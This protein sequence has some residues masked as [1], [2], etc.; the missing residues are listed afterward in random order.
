MLGKWAI[1]D[2]ETTGLDASYEHI[3]D[4]GYLQFDGLKLIRSYSSLV[5]TDRQLSQFLQ[6]LTGITPEMVAKAP[7]WKVVKQDL[8]EL[9]GHTLIAHN[10]QFEGQFLLPTFEELKVSSQASEIDGLFTDTIPFFALL[11]PGRSSLNLESFILEHQI[12]DKEMHRGLE[13]S[14]DLLKVMIAEC[15]KLLDS[16]YQ[17]RIREIIKNKLPS[18]WFLNFLNLN[19]EELTCLRNEINFPKIE[20]STTEEKKENYIFERK[21]FSAEGIKQNF[22]QMKELGFDP[23]ASQEEMA[24]KV[25]Q[26]FKNKIHSLIQA[27]TGTGK[28]LGYL[29]PSAIF[30]IENREQ[31]LVATGTKSL[32]TQALDKDVPLL[33]KILEWP[34]SEFKVTKM[35]GSSNHYC[36]LKFYDFIS[37]GDF[38]FDDHPFWARYFEVYMDLL[39]YYNEKK[40]YEAMLTRENFPYVLKKISKAIGSWESRVALDYRNCLGQRCPYKDRCSYYH[41]IKS[42]KESHL[43][44]GNHALLMHWPKNIPKPAKIIVDEAHRLEN[45]LTEIASLLI[46]EEQLVGFLKILQLGQ[47]MGA[48][49]YLLDDFPQKEGIISGLRDDHKRFE[50]VFAEN[51]HPLSTLIRS[52]FL[53]NTRFSEMYWNEVLFSSI[54]S[55]QDESKVALINSLQDLSNAVRFFY[56]RL[57]KFHSIFIPDELSEESLLA[58]SRFDQMFSQLSDIYLAFQLLFEKDEKYCR[59]IRYS[60]ENGF[61]L[62]ISPIDIGEV[63]NKEIFTPADSVIMASATLTSMDGK[64]GRVLTEWQ[65]GYHLIDQARRFKTP[66]ILPPVFDYK[67]QADVFLLSEV[68]YLNDSSF[69]PT[70]IDILVPMIRQ[71]SGR[72][73][74]LFSSKVRF[75][76]ARE[77]LMSIFHH[78]LKVFSQGLGANVVE[79]FRR[80]NHSILIGMDSFGEG[81]DLPGEIV[82]FLYIDKVPDLRMDLVIEA[83]REFFQKKFG[84]EFQDY[85]MMTRVRLLLQKLGR[86]VRTSSDKGVILVTDS[87]VGK[88]KNETWKQFQEMLTPYQI[89]KI[90]A[91]EISKVL[92]SL[93][94]L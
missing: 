69:V 3:I 30:S 12:A 25:G 59:V 61:E 24:L 57:L 6:E 39:F 81:V 36:E 76:Q 77:L 26:S 31:V 72:S 91:G 15:E 64:Y 54:Q 45:E 92:E 67:G 62:K 7:E 17:E 58:F 14:I 29:L 86:L 46:T 40:S 38:F 19:R 73:L 2:L 85:F 93:K 83:R 79:E 41:G 5:K 8:R 78:E 22:T 68:P 50:S 4:V 66:L 44:L 33:R 51:I 71:I 70:V 43:I 32:Q 65:T 34:S 53:K 74:L 27:P 84:N 1:L 42:A 21:P 13:D 16:P 20:K 75:E 49:Y 47:G 23:R 94:S 28:T 89:T 11:N 56:E 90:K 82:Q 9:E 55:F 35:I 52:I 80:S 10:A 63:A 18:Y 88:W 37:K 48:L 87:R 60:V